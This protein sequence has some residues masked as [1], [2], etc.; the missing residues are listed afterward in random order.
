MQ[1]TFRIVADGKDITGLINDRLLLRTTDKP[2]MEPD[3]FELRIDDRDAAVA[4]SKKGAGIEVFP[5]LS[6]ANAGSV[7]ALHRR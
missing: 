6:R 5:R 7:W 4:L 1:P 3:K 2:G